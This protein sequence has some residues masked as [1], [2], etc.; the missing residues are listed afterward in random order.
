MSFNC[1]D[2]S[3]FVRLRS[4]DIDFNT[5][6]RRFVPKF[7]WQ[8]ALDSSGLSFF[9]DMPFSTY[10][11]NIHMCFCEMIDTFHA[12]F[13][14]EWFVCNQTH[15]TNRIFNSVISISSG[16]KTNRKKKSSLTYIHTE[17]YRLKQKCWNR[18]MWH[19]KCMQM[20]F[21]QG[22]LFGFRSTRDSRRARFTIDIFHLNALKIHM[23]FT[24]VLTFFFLPH[25][26][27][28]D[29]NQISDICVFAHMIQ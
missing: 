22:F 6:K 28:N 7:M 9:C 15:L 16:K 27:T 12:R 24:F 21:W 8:N 17:K 19:E 29:W 4:F 2:L 10:I 18:K 13:S 25:S 3:W 20:W 5:T 11:Y 1:S 14:F 26:L 23:F